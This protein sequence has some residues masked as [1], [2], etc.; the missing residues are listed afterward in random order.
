MNTPFLKLPS[1][2]DMTYQ[3]KKTNVSTIMVRSFAGAIMIFLVIVGVASLFLNQQSLQDSRDIKTQKIHAILSNLIEPVLKIADVTEVRRLLQLA[4]STDE[5]Y[6]VVDRV[7]NILMPDYTKS[8]LVNSLYTNSVTSIKCEGMHSIYKKIHESGFW[9]NCSRLSHDEHGDLAVGSDK[10][11][12]F[13]RHKSIYI[14]PI[15]L[16]F[17]GLS[18]IVLLLM[19]GWF[20]HILY[21]NLIAP[22]LT[23]GNKISEKNLYPLTV[24]PSNSIIVNSPLEI[25]EIERAF[26]RLLG[27]LQAEHRQ[28]TDSEKK[29]ALFDLA[30]RVAHDIRSPLA[31]IEMTLIASETE[32]P[33]DVVAMQ[34]QAIRNIKEM[35]NGLLESYRNDKLKNSS[36]ASEVT[37]LVTAIENIISQK[38]HEWSGLPCNISLECRGND[39]LIQTSANDLLRVLSNLLNNA[40]ESLS[41]TRDIHITLE[42]TSTESKLL[43]K[44]S[45]AGIP[46]MK[47]NDVLSGL[48]LRQ[49]G[50]GLGLSS[51]RKYMESIGGGLELTSSLGLGTQVMLIFT[52]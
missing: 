8:Y 5:I 34:K 31:V 38:K 41:D 46:E 14:S 33:E 25:Y 19:I 1:G 9:I 17:S 44:D 40:Y 13:S 35:A 42:T 24:N 22:L 29:T 10:L 18:L 43:I 4:S 30:A 48:S 47:I 21:K 2:R 3:N 23:L 7:G 51:A 32:I 36:A 37:S 15:I 6:V 45:G 39:K 52:H 50:N 28:R 26:D 11:L 27:N 12:S 49:G 20:R 16:Y